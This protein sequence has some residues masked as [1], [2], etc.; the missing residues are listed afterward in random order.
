[1]KITLD[2]DT[3]AQAVTSHLRNSGVTAE[4]ARVDFRYTRAPFGVFAEVEL[5]EARVAAKPIPS[6]VV[7]REPV[8]PAEPT[9]PAAPMVSLVD[10]NN[11]PPE[12]QT[13]SAAEEP[14]PV[15]PTSTLFGGG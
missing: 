8:T 13:E 12:V 5:S 4:I 2:Q 11:L 14:P 6:R 9:P 1:M 3:L 15:A 10:P 7:E